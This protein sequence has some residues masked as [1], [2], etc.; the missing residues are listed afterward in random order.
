MVPWNT[1]KKITVE[2]KLTFSYIY[3]ILKVS[4]DL[5]EWLLPFCVCTMGGY[6]V[7]IIH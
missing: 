6:L 1:K 5:K 4:L 2:Q 3:L 7:I